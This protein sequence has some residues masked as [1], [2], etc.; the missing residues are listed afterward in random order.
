MNNIQTSSNSPKNVSN[1][2]SDLNAPVDK[3]ANLT[4][5]KLSIKTEAM[6][7]EAF[8]EIL[9]QAC[10]GESQIKSAIFPLKKD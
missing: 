7:K 10:G 8:Q 3:P 5:P 2:N 9:N 1:F 6:A 4:M